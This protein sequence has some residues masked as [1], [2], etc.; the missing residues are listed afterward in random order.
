MFHNKF[1][2]SPQL[3]TRADF[4]ILSTSVTSSEL[5]ALNATSIYLM[6]IFAFA[7]WHLERSL[8]VSIHRSIWP[9][10][11]RS[12]TCQ[13]SW[14]AHSKPSMRKQGCSYDGRAASSSHPQQMSLTWSDKNHNLLQIGREPL[15][16]TYKTGLESGAIDSWWRLE[17]TA[18]TGDRVLHDYPSI[19]T[20]GICR[21]MYLHSQID[22]KQGRNVATLACIYRVSV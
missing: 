15:K 12:N 17:W 6:H 2:S 5:V 22:A 21:F 11:I 19:S 1:P 9:S 14:A 16:Y 3:Q 4:T 10:G 20:P 13:Y 18:N 8:L 7:S